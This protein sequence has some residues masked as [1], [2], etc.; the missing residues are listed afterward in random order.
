[1]ATSVAQAQTTISELKIKRQALQARKTAMRGSHTATRTAFHQPEG[2]T[3]AGRNDKSLV[4]A[5]TNW[6]SVASHT[7]A[8][9]V[10]TSGGSFEGRMK[11]IEDKMT[12]IEIQILELERYVMV[13]S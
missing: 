7:D 6:L 13:N 12:E 11:E 8:R 10:K 2:Q 5:F 1:M 3:R 9:K 4:G